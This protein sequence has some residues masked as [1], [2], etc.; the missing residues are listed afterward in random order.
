MVVLLSPMGY[1]AF[2][3]RYPFLARVGKLP[4]TSLRRGPSGNYGTFTR[5]RVMRHEGDST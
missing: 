1:L 5:V 3:D 2:H 4:E